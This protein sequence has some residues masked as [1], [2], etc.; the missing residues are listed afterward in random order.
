MASGLGMDHENGCSLVPAAF[1]IDWSFSCGSCWDILPR[2]C[3]L[4]KDSS[5]GHF[6]TASCGHWP[7]FHPWACS[8][9]TSLLL[10]LPV[11]PNNALGLSHDLSDSWP[12]W[13][14]YN[15]SFLPSCWRVGKNDHR[16]RKGHMCPPKMA[17]MS[18]GFWRKTV[19]SWQC[20][21]IMSETANL[22]CHLKAVQLQ[23]YSCGKKLEHYSKTK[24]AIHHSCNSHWEQ[25]SDRKHLSCGTFAVS[26]R[27]Y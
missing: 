11:T 27:K 23:Y 7:P 8:Y 19:L 4:I 16:Q 9:T 15:Q 21:N 20:H 24:Q 10:G 12:A 13:L 2:G 14:S 22:M 17:A 6:C 25:I 3:A 18:F 1:C 5:S 26:S